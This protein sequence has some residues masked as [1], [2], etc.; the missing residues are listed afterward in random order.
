MALKLKGIS[1]GFHVHA[2][3]EGRFGK[4]CEVLCMAK[5]GPFRSTEF[6]IQTLTLAPRKLHVSSTLLTFLVTETVLNGGW[7]WTGRDDRGWSREI[8]VKWKADQAPSKGC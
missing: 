8:E 1:T 5:V 3:N 2:H 7:V 4:R 6:I